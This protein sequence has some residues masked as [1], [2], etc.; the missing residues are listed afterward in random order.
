[1]V[2]SAPNSRSW[3]LS[4][5]FLLLAG[6][7][8]CAPAPPR[9]AIAVDPVQVDGVIGPDEWRDGREATLGSGRAKLRRVGD[10]LAV[11]VDLGGP[12]I[13]TVLVAS[14]DR[15]WLLHASA[16][17]GTGEYRCRPDGGCARTRDFAWSCRDPSDRPEA[18]ACRESFLAAEG[19]L[20]NVNPEAG[21]TREFLISGRR[22]GRPLRVVVTG[23]TF[24]EKART[25][26][27]VTDDAASLAVQQG[28][29]PPEARFLTPSWA[30]VE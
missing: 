23:L 9:P 17:L 13:A 10:D 12:G 20:A 1:M 19:W 16:A 29:L 15:V 21:R 6:L 22:F 14:G 25:W 5:G 8:G 3:A 11:L 26:P 18:R 27:P 28:S 4:A 7:V 30:E 24:P 2:L